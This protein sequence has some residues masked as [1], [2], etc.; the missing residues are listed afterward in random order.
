MSLWVV[1]SNFIVK[2]N[3]AWRQVL[4]ADRIFEFMTL[5]FERCHTET[6]VLHT[7]WQWKQG[8]KSHIYLTGKK[9]IFERCKKFILPRHA[10]LACICTFCSNHHIKFNLMPSRMINTIIQTHWA[11]HTNCLQNLIAISTTLHIPLFTWQILSVW[12]SLQCFSAGKFAISSNH[13]WHF[14]QI[15]S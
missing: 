12:Y 9:K 6:E 1:T 5:I 11:N 13:V 2:A 15:N 7:E 8:T 4:H 10:Y 14:I 3:N